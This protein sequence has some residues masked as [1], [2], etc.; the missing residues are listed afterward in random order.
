MTGVLRYDGRMRLAL[1]TL[2]AVVAAAIGSAA[3]AEDRA[4]TAPNPRW[5]ACQGKHAPDAPGF[6]KQIALTFDDG[7]SVKYT[8][9]V[10]ALLRK[11]KVPA[12]FFVVGRR[13]RSKK[14]RALIRDMVADPLFDVG[15]HSYSH[16]HMRELTPAAVDREIDD[17]TRRLARAG[18]QVRFF[19]FPYS[20]SS[21][22]TARRVRQRGYGVAGWHIDSVD[23]CFAAGRG[24]CRT[25]MWPHVPD[26]F[27]R[28]MIQLVVHRARAT[29]GG[30]VLL[31]DI[32]RWTVGQLDALISAL[33]ADG[34]RFVALDD[35]GVFPRL[36]REVSRP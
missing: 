17:T 21:C 27:R 2:C 9:R 22:A 25:K 35:A 3:V 33:R 30:I 26:Q 18:A 4:A 36:N 14:A 31:H 5:N 29:D 34:F 28:D 7:P 10:L 8:P 15:N 32:H 19:R 16:P 11:R 13:V 24:H 1:A 6:G 12:T 20:E 23:W